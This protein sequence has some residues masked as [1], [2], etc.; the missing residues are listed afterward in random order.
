VSTGAAWIG[1]TDTL[2]SSQAHGG[3]VAINYQQYPSVT[4]SLMSTPSLD[5]LPTPTPRALIA[6]DQPDVLIALR[7]LLR[8]A[9][10]QVEAVSSPAEVIEKIQQE[11]FDLVLMDLNYARDTTSGKEGLDLF[12]QKIGTRIELL[13][14]FV[15]FKGLTERVAPIVGAAGKCF[16]AFGAFCAFCG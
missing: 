11:Q 14:G 3:G 8:N 13:P 2:R 16:C 15:G 1:G 12:D 10:Y 5:T 6:D 9:G 7:L 4:G